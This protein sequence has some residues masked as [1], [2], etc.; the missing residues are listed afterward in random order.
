[1]YTIHAVSRLSWA[2]FDSLFCTV[3]EPNKRIKCLWKEMHDAMHPSRTTIKYVI[4]SVWAG[5]EINIFRHFWHMTVLKYNSYIFCTNCE[6]DSSS[7][8]C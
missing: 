7:S 5:S 6:N 3:L 4:A 8:M 2:A 1:M